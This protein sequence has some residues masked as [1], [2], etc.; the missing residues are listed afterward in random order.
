M[1]LENGKRVGKGGVQYAKG[2]RE[3]KW[4]KLT[5]ND[6]DYNTNHAFTE[7]ELRNEI[8]A[9]TKVLELI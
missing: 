4:Y 9:M 2:N 5:E 8:D 1:I 3:G 6:I 7:Q